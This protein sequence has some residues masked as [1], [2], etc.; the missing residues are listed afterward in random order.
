MKLYFKI[1]KLQFYVILFLILLI[2]VSKKYRLLLFGERTEGIAIAYGESNV[3]HTAPVDFDYTLFRF[4]TE[5][6][7]FEIKGPENFIYKPGDRVRVIYNKSDPDQCMILSFS[8]LYL[9]PNAMI[10]GVLLLFW[11]AFYTSFAKPERRH[12]PYRKLSA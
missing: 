9:S 10:P 5:K 1:S 12:K 2:P 3:R 11:I 6:G 4:H 8:Y 7:S